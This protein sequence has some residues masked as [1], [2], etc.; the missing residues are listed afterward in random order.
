MINQDKVILLIRGAM[1]AGKSEFANYIKFLNKDAVICT[2]DDYFIDN[3]GKYNFD[4]RKLPDAHNACRAKFVTA[5]SD[6]MPLIIVAN[7]NAK[8]VDFEFYLAK[9]REWGYTVFSLVVENRHGGKNSHGVS[10]DK[11]IK[12][13]ENIKNSLKLY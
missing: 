5:M 3:N 6:K 9:A 2:A 8:A 12:C 10:D 11:V 1:G 4:P 13:A 7:T